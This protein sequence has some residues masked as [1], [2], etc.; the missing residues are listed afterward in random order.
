M[1]YFKSL[2]LADK[3]DCFVSVD[4]SF[5]WRR[6]L[7]W[8]HDNGGLLKAHLTQRYS[9]TS[10]LAGLLVSAEIGILF[11]PSDVIT[12][13]RT[14][15]LEVEGLSFGIVFLL[16]IAIITTMG[17]ILSTFTGE[18]RNTRVWCEVRSGEDI[19]KR[20]E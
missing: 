2:G 16:S 4:Q 13:V 11:S 10:V 14:E 3:R 7:V 20:K 15:A 1:L 8:S 12:E 9:S 17:T 6:S 5:Y 19:D 18:E